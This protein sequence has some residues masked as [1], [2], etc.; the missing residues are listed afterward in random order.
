MLIYREIHCTFRCYLI[1]IILSK[2]CQ[3]HKIAE[4]ASQV[5]SGRSVNYNE[6][7]INKKEEAIEYSST[8]KSN[9]MNSFLNC[10]SIDNNTIRRLRW[11]MKLP[12]S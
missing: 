7:K 3:H 12:W 4:D 11:E 9:F 5:H 8:A 2:Y 1:V 10:L 6:K